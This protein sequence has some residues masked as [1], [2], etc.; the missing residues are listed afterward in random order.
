M[1]A[2]AN[3]GAADT[4]AASF[5]DEYPGNS[6]ANGRNISPWGGNLDVP[7]NPTNS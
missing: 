2:V 7:I 1:T 5:G 6:A 3:Q 4:A